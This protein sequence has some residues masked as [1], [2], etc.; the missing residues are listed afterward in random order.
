MKDNTQARLVLNGLKVTNGDRSVSLDNIEIETHIDVEFSESE[1]DKVMDLA[2]NLCNMLV[3]FS[4]A[5]ID[6]V[7]KTDELSREARRNL[8]AQEHK[9]RL[10]EMRVADEIERAKHERIHSTKRP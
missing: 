8:S 6:K 2:S 4:S 5:A 10:E 1:Y 9:Q 7:A 3:G